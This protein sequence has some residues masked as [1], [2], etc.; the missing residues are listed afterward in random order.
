MTHE[1]TQGAEARGGPQNDAGLPNAWEIPVMDGPFD[2][3]AETQAGE[4][5]EAEMSPGYAAELAAAVV[6][7]LNAEAT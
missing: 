7:G 6:L 5:D 4:W 3:V 1:H 2:L